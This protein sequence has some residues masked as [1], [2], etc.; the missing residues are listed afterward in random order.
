MGIITNTTKE[1][2]EEL[3]QQQETISEKILIEKSK[4]K[5]TLT[6]SDIEHHIKKALKNTSARMI[7]LLIKKIVLYDDKIEI[8]CNYANKKET[9]IIESIDGTST[10]IPMASDKN[11][12]VI[13]EKEVSIKIKA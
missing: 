9:E 3:E 4:Q 10:K 8:Y 13:E 5:M 2:L 12:S 11:N 1:R 7:D 6:K